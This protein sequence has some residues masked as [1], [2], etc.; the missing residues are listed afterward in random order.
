MKRQPE[1]KG[2]CVAEA[3]TPLGVVVRGAMAGAAGILSM[4][5]ASY[6]RYRRGGGRDSPMAWELADVESLQ[7]AW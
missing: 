6:V 5:A 7:Q 2:L 1:A 3:K 4:D